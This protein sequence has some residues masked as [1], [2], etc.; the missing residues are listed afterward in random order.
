ML[1]KR[2]QIIGAAEIGWVRI[3]TGPRMN[4]AEFHFVLSLQL[5]ELRAQN[6]GVVRFPQ[7]GRCGSST[8]RN[9]PSFGSFAQRAG[10]GRWARLGRRSSG[11]K[12]HSA[13]E[14]DCGA[15]PGSLQVFDESSMPK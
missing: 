11:L 15:A 4:R 14:N 3:A 9:V 1:C 6:A 2:N 5:S 8:D 13:D 10:S 7:V 12:C